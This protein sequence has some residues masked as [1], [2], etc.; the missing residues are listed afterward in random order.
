MSSF[1][2][3]RPSSPARR[4]YRGFFVERGHT[5]RQIERIRSPSWAR[6]GQPS[7]YGQEKLRRLPDPDF[8][9]DGAKSVSKTLDRFPP[10]LERPYLWRI[11]E[12]VQHDADDQPVL[13]ENRW[14]AAHVGA[15]IVLHYFPPAGEDRTTGSADIM[16]IVYDRDGHPCSVFDERTRRLV[17]VDTD[18]VGRPSVITIPANA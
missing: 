14:F 17:A 12:R 6:S 9:R 1:R 10:Q 15:D 13:V 3:G 7:P 8:F 18:D 5:G 4:A 16:R 2:S 11:S